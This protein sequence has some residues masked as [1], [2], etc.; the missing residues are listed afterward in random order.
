MG[1]TL[2]KMYAGE[3]GIASDI[4]RCY[5]EQTGFRREISYEYKTVEG[6]R[7]LVVTYGYVPPDMVLIH[8]EDVTERRKNEER[9]RS[10]QRLEAIGQLAGGIA[11]DFNNLLL[12]IN[13]NAEFVL[14]ALP[15]EDPNRADVLEIRR[16]GRRAAALTK[17]LLAFGRRQ[18]LDPRVLNL[19]EELDAL[20]K[21]LP[22]L[23]GEDIEVETRFAED[24]G[25]V[26]ADPGQIEQVVVNLAVNA[27]D[28]MPEGGTL[29]IE[30]ANT[31][32]DEEAAEELTDLEPGHYVVLAVTDTGIGMDGETLDRAF[33]PFF[34][35]KGVGKGTGLGLATVYG[36]VK[37]SGGTVWI[38]S[39][40]GLGTS[41][42]VYLPRIDEEVAEARLTLAPVRAIGE[43]TVLVVEDEL[44]VR[45]L[46]V[47]ILRKVGY[48]VL[49]AESGAAALALVQQHPDVVH[50]LLTDVVMPQ[51][52]GRQLAERL[53]TR[54]PEMK[55]LYMSGYTD[56]AIVHH[57]VLDDDVHFIGKPFTPAALSRKVREILAEEPAGST[58]AVPLDGVER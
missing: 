19:N 52:S 35:T 42:Q 45:D 40:P 2:S 1:T 20:G 16:A 13:S 53:T 46:A 22:R 32:L 28:A 48:R 56:N 57:G 51:M 39:A 23:L 8:T 41:I 18:I 14:E 27:R 15:A 30:T 10:S 37:Q 54:Y 49:S 24:L 11:H 50:L 7:D 34:T 33:E 47:R 6:R 43:E 38:R 44:S 17:Q 58:G 12:V 9:V 5:E 31:E 25:N 29:T 26:R 21:M 3:P 36:I 4:R 55:V